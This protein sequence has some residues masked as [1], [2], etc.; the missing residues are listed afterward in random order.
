M[1]GRICLKSSYK[2]HSVQTK[3]LSVVSPSQPPI[4]LNATGVIYKFLMPA[5]SSSCFPKPVFAS[6]SYALVVKSV[7]VGNS[8]PSAAF[9]QE[10]ASLKFISN[11]T[12]TNL[13]TR[14]TSWPLSTS[15][16]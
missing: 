16:S 7:S 12:D 1:V 15:T 10:Q 14:L 5:I 3:L 8:P 4:S 13:S 2:L 9:S 11:A 6:F